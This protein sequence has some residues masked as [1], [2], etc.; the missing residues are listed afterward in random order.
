MDQTAS[1]ASEGEANGER[2]KVE[3]MRGPD[4]QGLGWTDVGQLSQSRLREWIESLLREAGEPEQHGRADRT[5]RRSLSE[6]P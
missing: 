6:P 5:H 1:S 2:R 3:H 4:W